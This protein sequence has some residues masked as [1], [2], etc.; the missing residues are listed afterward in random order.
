MLL[1]LLS[2]AL[3]AQAT[4]GIPDT[5]SAASSTTWTD[6]Y[7][8]S[9]A[10]TIFVDLSSDSQEDWIELSRLDL[11]GTVKERGEA[12][13]AL[14]AA[15]IDEFLNVKLNQYFKDE[16]LNL[17]ISSLPEALQAIVEPILEKGAE[18]A[19]DA[20]W[21]A[22]SW[23]WHKEEKYVP[24]EMIE[25][26]EAVA[27]GVC[28]QISKDLKAVEFS[29]CREEYTRKI[30]HVNMLPELIRMACTGEDVAK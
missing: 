7:Q 30:K 22:M 4:Y 23:V 16:L 12:H 29:S 21:A 15:D 28:T 17:D 25:E 11:V 6:T 18:Y 3:C 2:A 27:F 5:Y 10:A 1:Q 20:F 13:G 14:L 19:P 8:G 24:T 26:M 9:K